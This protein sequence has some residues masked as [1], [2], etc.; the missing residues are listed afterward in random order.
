MLDIAY[1]KH[2]FGDKQSPL[3]GVMALDKGT[4]F[5]PFFNKNFK[6]NYYLFLPNHCGQRKSML[7]RLEETCVQFNMR[8]LKR[9]DSGA[10]GFRLFNCAKVFLVLSTCEI[11]VRL[12]L[13]TLMAK[14][15]LWGA[16]P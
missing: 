16:K 13:S 7:I 12:R 8:K 4:Q 2:K 1:L 15:G 10:K 11:F 6:K 9:S 14:N 5:F 3:M